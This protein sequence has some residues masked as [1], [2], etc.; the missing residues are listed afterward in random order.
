M[1]LLQETLHQ[2]GFGSI[3]QKVNERQRE[4]VI[5]YDISSNLQMGKFFKQESGVNIPVFASYS[6]AIVNPEYNPLDPDIPLKEAIDEAETELEKDSIIRNSRDMVTRKA[7]AVTNVKMNKAGTK[8]HFYSL[9]NWSTSFSLN[10]MSSQNPNL[11]YYNTRKMRM[12]LSY[13]FN[14]RPVN[15]QPLKSVKWLSSN[16]LR[17]IKDFNFN[18]TPSKLS[19]RTDM[20]RYYMEKQVRN[21]NNPG[22]IVDPTF[23]KDFMWNRYFDL[24]FDITKNLRFNFSNTNMARIDEPDGRWNR[25]GDDYE[26]YR[27]SLWSSILSGGRITSYLHSFDI[28]YNIPI[29]KIPL[30]DWTSANARYGGTYAWSAGPIIP[31]DPVYGPTNLGNDIKNS[32]TIQLNGQLNMVNLY[33][34]IG[35]LKDINDKFR[36]GASRQKE[37]E[38]RTKTKVYSKDNLYLREGKGRYVNHNLKTEVISVEVL[39]ENNQAVEVVTETL[40]DNRI[41]IT[42]PKAIRSATVTVTGTIQKGEN[43]LIVITETSLRVL[44]ALRTVNVTYSKSGGTLLP[45]YL[46]T[47]Q[48]FNFGFQNYNGKLAPGFPFAAGWQDYGYAEQ[49][50]DN[51]WLTRDQAMNNAFTMNNTERFTFRANIEPFNGLKIDLTA[52][53]MYATNLSEYYTADASGNLPSDTARGLRYGGNFSMSYISLGT[54]FEKIDSEVDNSGTFARLKE[55]YRL[56]ISERLGMD[57][58]GVPVDQLPRDSSGYVQGYGATSQA[59]LIPAFLAAYGDEDVEKVPLKAVRTIAQILPNWQVRFDGL[60]KIE[61]LKRVVNSIVMNHSYRSTYSV[62]SFQYNP[63]FMVDVEGVPVAVDLKGNFMVEQ[64]INTVSINESFSPLF[65]LNMDWKNSLTTRV[66]YRRSR[67][68]AMNMAN[69]QVNEVNSGEIIIGGGYRFN[70]VPLII[71]QREL[72]SDLNVR[73]DFSMRNNRTVIRKLEDISGSEITAGQ[74]IF[75]LKASADYMLSDKFVIRLFYDQRMTNPYISNSY[76]NANYNVGFSLTFTL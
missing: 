31:D 14:T 69:T 50:F 4:Q 61:A 33:N 51:Q 43:P 46:P 1:S 64:N 10:D 67:T 30:L 11:D 66:E 26:I 44:M 20:D 36:S 19:W 8:K 65:D 49:A 6:K 63:F 25:D 17:L 42:S 13:N 3:E 38:S 54:S 68:V 58:Y 59:V 24:N 70:Q 32:S 23:K 29:N 73:L 9:S 21:L 27:D 7:F 47:P 56:A 76:P 28:S 57:H 18:V 22:F 52:N 60:G 62:G 48:T 16:W 5:Q 34:K 2:P 37:A 71:N 55:D 45:G 39:D 15:V 74:R 35:Y 72:S 53:H 41:M 12:N 75:S 40:S